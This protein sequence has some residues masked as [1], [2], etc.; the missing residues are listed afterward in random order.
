MADYLEEVG[1]LHGVESRCAGMKGYK[2]LLSCL[3]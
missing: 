3:P 1:V 2:Y